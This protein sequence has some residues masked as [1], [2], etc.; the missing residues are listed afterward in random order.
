MK[1]NNSDYKKLIQEYVPSCEQEITDQKAILD[2]ITNNDDVLERTNL[3]AHLTVSA[4]VVNPKMDKILFAF[5]NIYKAWSWVGGHCDG[6]PNMLEKALEE[7]KEETGV[8]NITPFNEDILM[9][10]TILVTNHIKRG[11]YVPDHLHLNATFLLIANE[12]DQVQVKPD[13][14]SGVKWFS[15]SN[16]LESVDEERM[17]VVYQKAFDKIKLLKKKKTK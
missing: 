12:N 5:H 4:M 6:N 1:T 10:D 17:K 16:V 9:L 13:E 7:A 8:A 14:N 11:H 3:V 2:F 15:I